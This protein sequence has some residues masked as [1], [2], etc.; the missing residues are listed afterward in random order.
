MF[1]M[2]LLLPTLAE[3]GLMLIVLVVAIASRLYV[4]L[5]LLVVGTIAYCVIGGVVLT[6]LEYV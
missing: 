2:G 6:L 5:V 4:L 1:R 3:V